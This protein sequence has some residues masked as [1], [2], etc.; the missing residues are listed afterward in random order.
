MRARRIRRMRTMSRAAK[1]GFLR[2][3]LSRV[4]N[5]HL[6]FERL[7]FVELEPASIKITF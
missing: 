5:N 7:Y 1:S 3:A 6:P 2:A 4:L